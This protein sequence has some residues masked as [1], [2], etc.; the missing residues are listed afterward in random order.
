MAMP[1]IEDLEYFVELQT[2]D[3]REAIW[4]LA[5]AANFKIALAAYEAAC[6]AYPQDRIMLRQ[7]ARIMREQIPDPKYRNKW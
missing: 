5:K 7:R 2:P 1:I 6:T 3:G 4:R